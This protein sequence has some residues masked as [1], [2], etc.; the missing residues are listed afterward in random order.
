MAATLKRKKR[1]SKLP[2][3]LSDVLEVSIKDAQEVIKRK[4]NGALINWDMGAYLQ[5]EKVEVGMFDDLQVEVCTICQAG[6]TILCRLGGNDIN[7][8]SITGFDRMRLHAIDEARTGNV[9]G[10]LQT[11]RVPKRDTPQKM[12]DQLEKVEDCDDHDSSDP[13]E[14]IKFFRKVI[15]ILRKYGL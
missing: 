1:R 15:K 7:N 3:K 11:I 8:S 12:I 10:A 2:K 5:K 14:N 13:V 4:N 9:Y 6:A